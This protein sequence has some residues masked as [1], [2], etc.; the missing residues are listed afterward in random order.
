MEDKTMAWGVSERK[1]DTRRGPGGKFVPLEGAQEQ[2]AG[3]ETPMEKRTKAQRNLA[4]GMDLLELDFLLGVIEST[5]GVDKN[6]FAM[7]KLT[8]NE[9]LRR[10]L[11][12]EIDSSA[13]SVYAVD[14]KGHYGK[15]IQCAA[16]KELARRTEQKSS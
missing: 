2:E 14:E 7:R 15:D 1:V 6:D 9:V 16:L 10:S 5:D 4:G 13:L 12:N 8:F 11:Q 3:G